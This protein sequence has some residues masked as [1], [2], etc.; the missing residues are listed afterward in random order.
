MAWGKMKAVTP[1]QLSLQRT[2]CE[3]RGS[4][5]R[6]VVVD[7]FFSQMRMVRSY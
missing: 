4:R 2:D 1:F 7:R 6:L 5:L 3:K